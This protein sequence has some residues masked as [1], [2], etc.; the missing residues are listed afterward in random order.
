M[1]KKRK[2]DDV[3]PPENNTSRH[4]PAKIVPPVKKFKGKKH[5]LKEGETTTVDYEEV[6]GG[7]GYAAEPNIIKQEERNLKCELTQDELSQGAG[8]LAGLNNKLT[9]IESEKKSVMAEYTS[10]IQ[11]C[12]SEI[13]VMAGI[14]GNGYEMRRV[15]CSVIYHKPE[16]GKK[17][18]QRRDNDF[19]WVE[20]MDASDWNLFNQPGDPKRSFTNMQ[21]FSAAPESAEELY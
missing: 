18:I 5:P 11:S 4:L 20:V 16:D 9:A 21:D 12:K 17:T 6:T 7:S 1:A 19:Q 10:K 8:K 2:G 3:P 13:G 15:H 14:L